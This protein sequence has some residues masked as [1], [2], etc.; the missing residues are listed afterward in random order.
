[1][2]PDAEAVTSLEPEELGGVLMSYLNGLPANEQS[3][4]NRPNFFSR[5]YGSHR[6]TDYSDADQ[7]RVVDAFLEAW[8]WLEREG[9]LIPRDAS[10]GH[11]FKISRRGARMKTRADVDGYRHASLPRHLVHPSILADVW[12]S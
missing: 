7:D 5:S 2:M 11:G 3:Q 12:P 1:M 6:F 10:G 9:L 4:L 8:M